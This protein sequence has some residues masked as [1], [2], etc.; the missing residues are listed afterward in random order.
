[1]VQFE[2]QAVYAGREITVKADTFAELHQA[3]AGIEEMERDAHFLREKGVE[4]VIPTYRKD[5]NENEYFGFKGRRDGR[6]V[7]FGKKREGGAFPFFPKGEEGYYDPAQG[8]SAPEQDA[9]AQNAPEQDAPVPRPAGTPAPNVA[10]GAAPSAEEASD[11]P[12]LD[13]EPGSVRRAQKRR[14]VDSGAAAGLDPEALQAAAQERF[15]RGVGELSEQQAEAFIEAV[16]AGQ[17]A[18]AG[19]ADLPF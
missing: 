12:A 13:A 18:S 11:E 10:A 2:A 9:S 3:L 14:L 17:I 16:E 19:E 4:D 6:N 8:R 5:A 7:T 1:M 15:G